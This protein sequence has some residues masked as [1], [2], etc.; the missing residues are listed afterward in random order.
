MLAKNAL[1]PADITVIYKA[2]QLPDAPPVELL[3]VPQLLDLLL[4]ALF[5][6]GSRLHAE[7]KPKYSY[8]LGIQ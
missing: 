8:L 1:N 6:P 7:H 4:D 3:R 2:Y 5:R